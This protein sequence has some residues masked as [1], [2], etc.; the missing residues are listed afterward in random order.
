MG[1]HVALAL[2]AKL[3]VKHGHVHEAVALY[4]LAVLPALP[5]LAV[6]GIT[7]MYLMEEPDEFERTVVVQS[8]LWAMGGVLGLTSVWGFL[9]MFY[10]NMP[11]QT[12]AVGHLQPFWLFPLFWMLMGMA[13]PL[14]RW[15]YR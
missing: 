4:G 9:E 3:V 6:L 14:V 12:L 7:G 8:M 10:E 2:I 13:T 1:A 15:R 5:L 11:Q